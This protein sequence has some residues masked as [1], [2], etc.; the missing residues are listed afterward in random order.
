MKILSSTLFGALV[1]AA[2]L[3]PTDASF[4]D[5]LYGW[6]ISASSTDPYVHTAPPG[7]G[8]YRLYVWLVCITSEVFGNGAFHLDGSLADR[9]VGVNAIPP[10]GVLVTSDLDLGPYTTP[11][12]SSGAH[13][14][15]EVVILDDSGIGGNLCIGETVVGALNTSCNCTL[16]CFPHA[17]TGFASD[18][19]APCVIGSCQTGPVTLEAGSWGMTKE[20]YR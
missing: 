18:G 8:L 6:T 16:L 17:V 20:R 1:V 5:E 12:L 7:T 3:A 11:C 15:L 2:T 19:T 13:P 4:P 9:I 14:V 10:F